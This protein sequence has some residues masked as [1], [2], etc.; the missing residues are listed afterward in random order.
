MKLISLFAILL[1]TCLRPNAQDRAI[2]SLQEILRKEKSDTGKIVL[3]IEISSLYQKSRPDSALAL[4]QTAYFEAKKKKFLKGQSWALAQMANANAS[5]GNYPNAL[6]YNFEQLDVEKVRGYDPLNIAIIYLNIALLYESVDEFSK[7]VSFG[8]GADSITR[9]N[10]LD[11]LLLYSLLDLGDI[12]EKKNV[13][14]SAVSYTK[15]CLAESRQQRNLLMQASAQN[16]LG[17]IYFKMGDRVNARKSYDSALPRL[18]ALQDYSNASESFL[19]LAR[20]FALDHRFD[21]AISYARKSFAISRDNSFLTKSVDAGNLLATLYKESRNA[22]SALFY[23]GAVMS[24]KDSIDSREKI[25]EFQ[26]IAFSEQLKVKDLEEQQIRVRGNIRS[27]ALLAGIAVFMVIAFLLYRNNMARKRTNLVLETQKKELQETL[28]E[29]NNAQKQLIQTAKM[30]S[31]GELTAG[32][33]HEIQNP[34]NFVNNFSEVSSELLEEM[35]AEIKQGNTED[36]IS[37]AGYI[38]QNLEKIGQH[39]RRA[40][41]IVKN[42]LQHSL[43]TSGHKEP[44]DVNKLVTD[45]LQLAYHGMKN[46]DRQFET[47]LN[48]NLDSSVGRINLIPPEIGRVLLN[49]FNNAFYAVEQKKKS[50]AKKGMTF[51]PIVSVITQKRGKNV[52]ISVADNG[53][54]I[55]KNITDKIF[56]PFFT[57]KPAGQGT[58][59]GLSLSYD[60]IKAHGGELALIQNDGSGA[61]FDIILS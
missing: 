28:Q 48:T 15:A 52:I 37:I 27:I 4:A 24:L 41:S 43:K 6:Q 17:N 33:A 16:N 32:I 10:K 8:L 54:G 31:L 2:D 13:L 60:I 50:S 35:K 12:Y 51:E 42:M 53:D 55:P 46:K 23:E 20:L 34:L 38:G 19:G 1:L 29:L 11:N 59:L 58:G 30:A 57:T 5:M 22:D 21:S 36:A 14:D 18:L 49:L 47:L 44:V 3:M 40:D 61:Q 9:A 26:S 25:N 7:S 39:G 45:Y 56:Q